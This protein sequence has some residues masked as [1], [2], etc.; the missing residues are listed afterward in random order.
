MAY[1]FCVSLVTIA[2]AGLLWTAPASAA[3]IA[4]SGKQIAEQWC[5]TC[6][7]VGPKQESAPAVGTPTFLAISKKYG[8]SVDMLTG[9]L[10][11]PHPPMPSLSLTRQ[12][13]SDLV[14][15]IGS[16]DKGEAKPAPGAA[17]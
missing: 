1:R 14:A 4:V 8:D 12:E 9:F 11:D 6:H 7:L 5:S 2:L 17:E 16:L 3:G 15:Y 13:I 10:A